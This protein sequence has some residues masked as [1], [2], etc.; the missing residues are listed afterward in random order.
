M[1]QRGFSTKSKKN[2]L[3]H[4]LAGARE[5]EGGADANL[6]IDIWPLSCAVCTD[7]NYIYMYMHAC[8]YIIYTGTYMYSRI[9]MHDHGRA[10]KT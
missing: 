5:S 2:P 3:I 1:T 7:D 4:F 8:I 9:M 6:L 10:I